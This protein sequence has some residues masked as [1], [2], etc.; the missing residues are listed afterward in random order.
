MGGL[1]FQANKSSILILWCIYRR[2]IRNASQCDAAHSAF[3]ATLS[4][5][6]E[7]F[8]TVS[9]GMSVASGR[10]VDLS[11]RCYRCSGVRT[12]VRAPERF[13]FGGPAVCRAE[14][15]SLRLASATIFGSNLMTLRS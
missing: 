4:F 1:S 14:S 7:P 13:S 10:R 8:A 12:C 2:F 3:T 15:Y 5:G 6:V 9:S 11:F